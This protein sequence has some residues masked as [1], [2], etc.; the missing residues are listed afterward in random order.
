M[1]KILKKNLVTFEY[2]QYVSN[3][4]FTILMKLLLII[5]IDKFFIFQ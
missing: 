2:L 3:K 5:K 4:I 1:I